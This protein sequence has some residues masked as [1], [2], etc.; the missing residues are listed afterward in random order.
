MKGRLSYMTPMFRK[1]KKTSLEPDDLGGCPSRL[2]AESLYPKFEHYW[3]EECIKEKKDRSL[4]RALFSVVGRWKVAE[5]FIFC[6]TGSLVKLVP[7]LLLSTLTDDLKDNSLSACIS[8][9]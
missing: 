2:Q 1:A 6:L 4:F 5:A 7:S 8:S 3:N 9:Q